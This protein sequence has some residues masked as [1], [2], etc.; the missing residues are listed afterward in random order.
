M[1]FTKQELKE[2][3]DE[4]ELSNLLAAHLLGVSFGSLYK[5]TKFPHKMNRTATRLL[6]AWLQLKRNNLPWKPDIQV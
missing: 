5:W 2:C 4:L 6:R 3:L 1:E